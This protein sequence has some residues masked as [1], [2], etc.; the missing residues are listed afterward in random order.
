MSKAVLSN[1]IYL[2]VDNELRD[3]L[4]SELLYTIDRMPVSEFPEIIQ[5]CVTVTPTTCSIP[6][7]RVDLIPEH[8]T[9]IDKRVFPQVSLPTPKFTP[10]DAQADAIDQISDGIVKAKP[11]FGKTIVGLGIAHKLGTKTLVICT[12]TAIR[13]MWIAEVKKWFGINAGVIGSGKF[14][15]DSPI[16]IA[17][18]QT[19][20]NRVDEVKQMFGL[21]IVDE[22]HRSVAHTFTHVLNNMKCKHRVGLSGTIERKDGKHVVLQDY[23]GDNIFVAPVENTIDPVVHLHKHPYELNMNEFTPWA[24][25]MTGLVSNDS[26]QTYVIGLAKMYAEAGHKVL[27]I[28]SRTCILERGHRETED[29]SLIV[30]GEVKGMDVRQKI[31]DAMANSPEAKI[32]WGTQS[33]FSEGVSINELSCVILATPINNDPLLEQ[34]AGRIM[35]IA[36]GKLEPVIV[37][38]NLGGNTG[39]SHANARKRFYINRGWRIKNGDS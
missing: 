19:L 27:V 5:N 25:V 28:S 9:I 23:F 11:G 39:K 22:V 1:R 4:C 33:I 17:N 14:E 6:A 29:T 26:Y 35:R 7:G 2:N 10:R 36:E 24:N 16:V 37:D 20:R 31:F 15:T 8:Y 32:L 12:T 34:I 21:V 3:K 38:I 30:T 13:D 18:I